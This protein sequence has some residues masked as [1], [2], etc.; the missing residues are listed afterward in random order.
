M[1]QH[2]GENEVVKVGSV[3]TRQQCMG[4][5]AQALAAHAAAKKAAKKD[6]SKGKRALLWTYLSDLDL[7]LVLVYGPK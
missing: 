4:M 7:E 5:C 6:T 3:F 1:K 2:V